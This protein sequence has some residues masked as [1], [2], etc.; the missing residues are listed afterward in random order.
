MIDF[1]KTRYHEEIAAVFLDG[2]EYD[3]D[4]DGALTQEEKKPIGAGYLAR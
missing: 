3:A 4:G 1:Y 2:V